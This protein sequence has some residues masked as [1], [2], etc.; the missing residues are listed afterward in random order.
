[1]GRFG[2]GHGPRAAEK[3][4]MKDRKVTAALLAGI[5]IA[6][7]FCYQARFS[8]RAEFTHDD[9]MN[10]WRAVFDPLATHLRDCVVFFRFSDSY[11]PFPELVY[12]AA[13]RLSGFN[14][15]PLRV[16]LLVVMG[17]N[18][19][20]TYS[21]TRRLTHSREVGVLAALLGSY[22]GNLTVFYF[23]TGFLYDI[24]CFFFYF[25]ALVFYLRIRQ[26]GRLLRWHE[27]VA[28]CGLYV[29]ALD[30]KELAVSLPVVI[31]AWE[32][33]FNP[34]ALRL[35]ALARWQYREFLPVW[36]TAI[37]TAAFIHGRVLVKGGLSAIGPYTVSISPAAYGKN[38]GHFLNELFFANNFFD[39]PRTLAFL[40]LLLAVALLAHSKKLGVCWLL[41]FVGVLPVAF[42]SERGLASVWLPTTG[43]L[44]CAAVVAVALRDTILTRLRRT[45]W[46][47]AGQVLL[48]ALAVFFMIR[49]HP[50]NRH[51]FYAWQPE[52]SSIREVRESFQR[53]CP[54]MRPK[55]TVLIVTDPLNGTFSTVFLIQLLY[56][57]SSIIINQLF[58]FDRPPG[59]EQ[60]VGY[61]YIFDFVNGRLVRL[62]PA[63]YAPQH[64]PSPPRSAIISESG[65]RGLRRATEILRRYREGGRGVCASP[66]ER[67]RPPLHRPLSFPHREDTLL[68]GSPVAPVLQVLRLR[69]RRR[70]D[71]V[72]HGDRASQLLRG[73]QAARR[74]QRHSDA[75]ARRVLGR[76]NPPAGRAL[77]NA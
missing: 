53:L 56:R 43:L 61:N 22:H 19:L 39:A 64:L 65:R 74:P 21:F 14:L 4:A 7:Y 45:R 3:L 10:C 72:R 35:P 70:R 52:Y 15:F 55:S 30:S 18:I 5:F 71:Q 32:M 34:P 68:L 41:Y 1:M 63:D 17:L 60:W 6:G 31:A 73:A 76:R 40:L 49:V 16:L 50:G 2:L 33:L 23:N 75:E 13:F 57:D 51:I 38:T 37:M 25:S 8:L 48:F 11:R 26:A 54:A 27:L 29:L 9:L 46:Q 24:F 66:K 36:I 69:R 62:N 42:I 58:R 12:R 77:R 47:T 28:F 20:L 67:S 44:I 59:R